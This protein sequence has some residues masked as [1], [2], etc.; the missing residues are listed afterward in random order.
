[1]CG[2][3]VRWSSGRPWPLGDDDLWCSMGETL[4][5]REELCAAGGGSMRMGV[6]T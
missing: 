5:G 6:K 2:G 4:M 1:M 3:D